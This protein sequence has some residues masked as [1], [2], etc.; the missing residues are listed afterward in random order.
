MGAGQIG[1]IGRRHVHPQ[2]PRGEPAGRYVQR[3]EE[4]HQLSLLAVFMICIRLFA[5][6]TRASAD[7]REDLGVSRHLVQGTIPFRDIR[8]SAGFRCR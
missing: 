7:L 4:R 2:P 6:C 3:I 5:T 1:E 8:S